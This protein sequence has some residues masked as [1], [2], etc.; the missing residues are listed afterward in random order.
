MSFWQIPLQEQIPQEVDGAMEVTVERGVCLQ[1]LVH[2]CLAASGSN[3]G[4]ILWSLN[5]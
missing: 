4:N 2:A 1:D 5:I 3:A